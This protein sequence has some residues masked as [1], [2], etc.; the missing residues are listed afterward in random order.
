[1]VLGVFEIPLVVYV[2]KSIVPLT[3]LHTRPSMPLPKPT[4]PPFNPPCLT[5]FS[6]S[7]ITPATA[8]KT[9]VKSD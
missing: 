5:P 3:G 2:T 1:M 7:K 6:G 8:P 9:F 4:A